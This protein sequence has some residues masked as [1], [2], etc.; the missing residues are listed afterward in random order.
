MSVDCL[1]ANSN[2]IFSMQCSNREGRKLD[3]E[4]MIF[5]DSLSYVFGLRGRC[6]QRGTRQRRD[7]QGLLSCYVVVMP[8]AG[9]H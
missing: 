7:G 2:G 9:N 8:R 4:M 3:C 6:C 1:V 5:Y